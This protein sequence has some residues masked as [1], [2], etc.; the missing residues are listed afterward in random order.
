[1]APISAAS[2]GAQPVSDGPLT[3]RERSVLRLIGQGH[4]NK[5]I[6][7]ELNIAPETVKSHTKHIFVK[8]DT[9]TRAQA[10]GRA[11]QLGLL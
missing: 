10:I 5:G 3:A 4:S 11:V 8:L 7:R 6:A 1:M 9:Q 2:A